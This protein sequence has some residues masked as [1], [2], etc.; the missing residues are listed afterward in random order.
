MDSIVHSLPGVWR[1]C[2]FTVCV[3]WNNNEMAA[4]FDGHESAPI[5]F[6][7]DKIHLDNGLILESAPH[8]KNHF[9]NI[10]HKLTPDMVSVADD[11]DPKRYEVECYLTGG[12]LRDPIFYHYRYEGY[13]L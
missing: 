10:F 11:Y 9:K 1:G 2:P 3:D 4:I 7:V 6:V 5:E 12:R 13:A 8:L